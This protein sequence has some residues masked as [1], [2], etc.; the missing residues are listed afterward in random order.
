MD[1]GVTK[2]AFTAGQNYVKQNLD[3]KRFAFLKVYFDVSNAYI[4]DKLIFMFYPFNNTY[5]FLYKP[6]L[7]IPFMALMSVVMLKGLKL[8]F[9]NVFHP[10]KIFLM[11]TRA[12]A[13]LLGLSVL[14][15]G[16]SIIL[17]ASANFFS[18]LSLCGY[19]HFYLF[20]FKAFSLLQLRIISFIV[21]SYLLFVYFLF[22]S[23]CLQFESQK[24]NSDLGAGSRFFNIAIAAVDTLILLLYMK[25]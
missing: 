12:I 1:Y 14:Y 10:E 25:F 2:H 23:R 20:V 7:Y 3:S 8:G 17:G 4:K 22:F 21:G 11:Q 9:E 5:E 6:D 13:I 15:K 19:K 24:N 16:L 18:V